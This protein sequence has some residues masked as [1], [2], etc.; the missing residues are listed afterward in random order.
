MVDVQMGSGT[1]HATI[2][3]SVAASPRQGQRAGRRIAFVVINGLKIRTVEDL[4]QQSIFQRAFPLIFAPSK[5]IV[6]Q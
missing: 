1:E 4:F 6:P 5:P 3:T 2:A